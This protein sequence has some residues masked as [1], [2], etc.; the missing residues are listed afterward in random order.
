MSI[1]INSLKV[2]DISKKALDSG[3]LYQDLTLDMKL[4]RSYNSQLNRG[5]NLTDIQAS[6]DLE[7]VIN[8]I[9]NAFMTAPGQKILNPTFGID[10]RQYLFEPVDDFLAEIIKYDIES[11]LPRQEPRITIKNVDVVGDEDNQHYNVSL[12]IDIPTLGIYGVYIKSKLDSNGY[13]TL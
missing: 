3:Y 4:N 7:A 5:E 8:S 9:S 1:K 12:Q 2:D 10:L 11:K 13:T 6:Y